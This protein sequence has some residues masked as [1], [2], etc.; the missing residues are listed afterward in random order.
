MCKEEL[1]RFPVR[2]IYW[3]Y[4]FCGRVQI[5]SDQEI[6][7]VLRSIFL[8][9]FTCVPNLSVFVRLPQSPGAASYERIVRYCEE[10]D[11][12]KQAGF[13]KSRGL[14]S[15]P[16]EKYLKLSHKFEHI[17]TDVFNH[18]FAQGAIFGHI[19]KDV[20]SLLKKDSRVEDLGVLMIFARIFVNCKWIVTGN[21]IDT[22]QY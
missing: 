18:W 5:S 22:E 21:R 9:E 8:E 2:L 4:H 16:S 1:Q 15:W 20:I 17:L 14:D 11:A 10:H 12:L 7:G 3:L 19:I 13:N 6:L